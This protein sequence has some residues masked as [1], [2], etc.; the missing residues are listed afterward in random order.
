[1]I[2]M[3]K[4]HLFKTCLYCVLVLCRSHCRKWSLQKELFTLLISGWFFSCLS[5][6]FRDDFYFTT[7]VFEGELL[8]V[9]VCRDS[10]FTQMC[11]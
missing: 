10:A 9:C 6:F 2:S 3:R 11:S 1:M 4:T 5:A 8:C 7:S